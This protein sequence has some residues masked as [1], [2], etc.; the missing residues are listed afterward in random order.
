VPRFLALVILLGAGCAE[1]QRIAYD[2]RDIVPVGASPLVS[3]TLRIELFEDA[4]H[5][6]L[7]NTLLFREDR[8]LVLNDQRICINAEKHYDSEQ[9][10]AQVSQVV[11]SHA[12][13]SGIWDRVWFGSQGHA[14]YVLRA[15]LVRLY[16]KQ[17]YS[18]GAAIKQAAVVAGGVALGSAVGGA[19]GGMA[20]VMIPGST[21][22]FGEVEIGLRDVVLY[23]EAHRRTIPLG[24]FK[25]RIVR[26]M[27]FDGDCWSIYGNVNAGLRQA[28]AELLLR[29]EDSIV[30]A[31]R[32][33]P[34]PPPSDELAADHTSS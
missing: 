1:P 32:P 2:M 7:E 18:R 26:E 15:R 22:T 31:E 12:H 30:H 25:K 4:R 16:G 14:D 13:R 6:L 11:A 21:G 5:T 8:D 9:V 29:L 34:P 24:E 20:A 23:D 10:S 3:K 17:T 33:P 28:V 19:L 27:P